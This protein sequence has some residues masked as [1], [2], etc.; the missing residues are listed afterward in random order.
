MEHTISVWPDYKTI[1]RWKP[2]V[3]FER[4]LFYRDHWDKY[5]SYFVEDNT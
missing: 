3:I 5:I 4:V 1:G 2:A